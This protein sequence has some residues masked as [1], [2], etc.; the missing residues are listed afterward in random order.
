MTLNRIET[1]LNLLLLASSSASSIRGTTTSEHD[2]LHAAM[3]TSALDE[4]LAE[5]RIVWL[6]LAPTVASGA[7]G[8]P[9]YRDV[10]RHETSLAVAR[11]YKSTTV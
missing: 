9:R 8:P 3:V 11:L 1:V 2:R 5:Q 10:P 4:A 6:E 7:A